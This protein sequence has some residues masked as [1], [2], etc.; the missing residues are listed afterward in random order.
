MRHYLLFLI[1]DSFYYLD[2][3]F[4][5]SINTILLSLGFFA[6]LSVW[7]ILGLILI[8]HHGIAIK[9]ELSPIRD[10][11]RNLENF[12]IQQVFKVHMPLWVILG[13]S[14]LVKYIYMHGKGLWYDELQ[15]VTHASLPFSDML[16]SIRT[17][18]P[19]PSLYYIQLHYWLKLGTSDL[20]IKSNSVIVLIVATASL[21]F[22]AYKYFNRHTAIIAALLFAIAPY[23]VNYGTEAR[24]YSLWMLLVIWIYELNNQLIISQRKFLPVVGLFL[25]TVAFLY[26]HGISFLILPAIYFHALIF[27]FRK[28]MK[29]SQLRIWLLTQ[30]SIIVAYIPWLQ[31]AWTIGSVAH[32]VVPG[33]KDII[34]TLFIHLLGYCSNCPFWLQSIII[35]LWLAV[36]IYTAVRWQSTQIAISA[37]LFVPILT[38]IVISHLIRPIWLFHGLGLIVPFLFLTI[39]IW[40]D[41]LLNNNHWQKIIA[42]IVTA[43][44]VIILSLALYN[45]NQTFVYPWDFKHAVQFVK[46]NVQSNEVI[47][48]ANERLFWCWNWYFLGPGQTNPIRTDYSTRATGNIKIISKP[49]RIEPP[50]DKDFWQIYRTIDKPLIN[51]TQYNKQTWDFEGL[52]VEYI[53]MQTAQ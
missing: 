26:L 36:C 49:S 47:Y 50:L 5:S 3:L 44:T 42:K 29:I 51:T 13:L 21:Y 14:I 15:S 34:T 45:Q 2:Y 17:Y 41:K 37:Y 9:M 16:I 46:A 4:Q 10:F 38:T 6:I 53:P 27:A 31:R 22:L 11:F 7:I 48:L 35:S 52:I 40:L 19:H 23:A 20:W 43:L 33:F 30:I 18:D 1:N 32:A 12:S 8:N 39:A 25:V 24:M 28:K